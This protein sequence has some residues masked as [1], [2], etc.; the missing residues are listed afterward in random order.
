M[1]RRFWRT[2]SLRKIETLLGQVAHAQ[3]GPLCRGQRVLSSHPGS[4][5][6]VGGTMRREHV[7]SWSCGAVGPQHA[8]DFA[9]RTSR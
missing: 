1:S 5:A 9:L 3:A 4:L 6:R 8:D 7:K 2:V